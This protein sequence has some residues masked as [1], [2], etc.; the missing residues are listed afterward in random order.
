MRF[1]RQQRATPGYDPNTRH[2]IY[3]QDAG[4]FKGVDARSFQRKPWRL[5]SQGGQRYC[6]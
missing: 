4:G 5:V 3:G 1:L 2:C 6:A